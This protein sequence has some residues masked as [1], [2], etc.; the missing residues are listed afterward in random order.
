MNILENIKYYAATSESRIAIKSGDSVLTYKQLEEYSNRLAAWIN[1]NLSSN[2]VPIVVYGHKNPYMIVCFLACVK[3]GRAYCPQDISIPDTRVMD[4]AECVNPEVIF[5]VEGDMD[6]DGYNVK[7]LDSIKKIIEEE[8]EEYCP[9]WATKPEDVYY[10][11]FTSGSTGKPKGVK[12]TF[13]CLNN[14]LDWSV[15][16]GSS[17]QDK[18]GKNFVNQAPFSFDLSVMD[19]YTSLACGG[20]LHT[21]TKKMQEDYNAMFEHFKQSDFR[22]VFTDESQEEVKSAFRAYNR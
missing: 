18:E 17:K 21:M 16:L 11:L 4:T 10:I 9:E 13:D 5:K 1:R 14:Y 22:F 19:L 20:T 12:I 8:Q 15:N 3:S 6:F 2:K 7:N